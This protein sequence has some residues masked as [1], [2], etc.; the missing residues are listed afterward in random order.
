[1]T[2]GHQIVLLRMMLMIQESIRQDS[3]LQVHLLQRCKQFEFFTYFGSILQTYKSILFSL[4]LGTM[5]GCGAVV[6]VV[7]VVIVVTCFWQKRFTR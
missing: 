7:I 3:T 4:H 6:V 1:M 5:I 2:I